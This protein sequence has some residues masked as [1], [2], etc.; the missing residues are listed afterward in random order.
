MGCAICQQMKVN[1]HLTIPALLPL[2]SSCTCPFQQLS[3]NLITNLPL[4][5]R[6]DPLLVVV[7][8][9]LS[10]GVILILCNKPIDVKGVVELFF[11][12]V[13]LCFRLHDHLISD[14]GPQFASAFA[15]ELACILGYD[16]KLSTTYHPQT[17]GETE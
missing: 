3:V 6:F 11:K 8:H 13:F 2:L 7:D 14:Q 12:N 5:A 17:D 10:K 1:T 16:L 4:S 9:S 15:T